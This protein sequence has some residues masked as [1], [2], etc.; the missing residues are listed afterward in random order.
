MSNALRT[1]IRRLA[2]VA[3]LAATAAP[4]LANTITVF[5]DYGSTGTAFASQ[6]YRQI[7]GQAIVVAPPAVNA[8]SI[9]LIAT[10]VSSFNVLLLNT[11]FSTPV[12][13]STFPADSYFEVDIELLPEDDSVLFNFDIEIGNLGT[14]ASVIDFDFSQIA[15]SV[16][17]DGTS[18]VSAPPGNYTLRSVDTLGTLEQQ[19]NPNALPLANLANIT[20]LE[21]IYQSLFSSGR[22]GET[23]AMRLD[24]VRLVTPIPEPAS[25][26]ASLIALGCSAGIRLRK[27]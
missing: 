24:E 8:D 16:L 27:R 20:Q 1:V 13:L 14:T 21:L 2:C 23:F 10:R 9:D 22:R 18:R 7:G 12:N 25:A 3:A 5:A 11:Q 4:A 26:M 6:E 17:P 19:Q 15:G